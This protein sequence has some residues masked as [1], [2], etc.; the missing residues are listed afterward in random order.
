MKNFQIQFLHCIIQTPTE[1]GLSQFSDAFNAAQQ[2]RHGNP[3][4]FRI[5]CETPVDYIDVGTDTFG[6]FSKMQ[7]HY[8]IQWVRPI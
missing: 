7:P 5:L 4:A 2:L 3:E 8:T 6:K 1:G